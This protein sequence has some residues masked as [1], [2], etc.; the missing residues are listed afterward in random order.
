MSDIITLAAEPRSRSGTGGARQT[1]RSQRTPAIIYG[2]RQEPV[3]ISIDS[4]E[5][6]R[7]VRRHGFLN[8]VFDIDLAGRKE[9]VIPRD[10]QNHPLTGRPLHVDFM[11]VSAASLLKLEVELAFEN[12]DKAPGIIRGGV[13][14]VVMRSIEVEC[15]PDAIPEQLTVDLT[16]LDIGDVVHLGAI[17]LPEGVGLAS[18]EADDT[19][20]S[21]APPTSEAAAEATEPTEDAESAS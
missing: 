3:M 7:Q 4:S 21:I 18:G 16:G 17:K 1:R 8:H 5:L 6:L 2:N 15:K 10:V 20:A 19:V 9:R 11:R 13:V 12:E 14:N